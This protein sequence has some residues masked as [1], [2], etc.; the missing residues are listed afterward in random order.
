LNLHAPELA[1]HDSSQSISEILNSPIGGRT[2]HNLSGGEA[3]RVAIRAVL[4]QRPTSLAIDCVLE[5]VDI[6]T[7]RFLF[8]ELNEGTNGPTISNRR[9]PN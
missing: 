3:A 1:P 2:L 6:E 8:K 4:R 5:Q 9:Q 7:R